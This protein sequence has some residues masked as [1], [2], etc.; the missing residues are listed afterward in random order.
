MSRRHDASNLLLG[1]PSA[2]QVANVGNEANLT[3][4]F[5]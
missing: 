3:V 2:E 4:H 1:R 5:P